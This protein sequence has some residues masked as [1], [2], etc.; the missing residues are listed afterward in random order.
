MLGDTAFLDDVRLE[1]PTVNVLPFVADFQSK[2]RVERRGSL[3][4]HLVVADGDVRFGFREASDALVEILATVVEL[5]EE[6]VL[7]ELG[8]AWVFKDGFAHTGELVA[9]EHLDRLGVWV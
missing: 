5:L 6:F 8:L 9:V 2:V 7:G 3:D 1:E 4:G